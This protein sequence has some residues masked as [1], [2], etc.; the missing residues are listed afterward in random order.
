MVNSWGPKSTGWENEKQADIMLIR[1]GKQLEIMI[2]LL[3]DV[4]QLGTRAYLT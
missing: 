1:L 3:Y 4:K 2:R